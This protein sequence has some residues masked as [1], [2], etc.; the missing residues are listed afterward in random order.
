MVAGSDEG[1]WEQGNNAHEIRCLVEA[2]MTPMQAIQAATGVAS[3]CLGLEK[4]IGTVEAGKL[5]DLVAVEGNPLE[6]ITILQQKER[7]KLVLKGGEAFVNRVVAKKQI[8]VAG[9]GD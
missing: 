5:A 9:G 7:I 8:A 6:D 1:G 3:E 4:Q 2:G